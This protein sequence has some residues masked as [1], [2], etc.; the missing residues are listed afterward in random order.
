MHGSINFH[1]G[2]Y[3]QEKYRLWQGCPTILCTPKGRLFAGWYSGGTKEP[4]KSCFNLLFKSDDGGLHWSDPLLVV[5]SLKEDNI[6]CIDIQLWLDPRGRMWLCWT[7]RDMNHTIRTPE[8]LQTYAAICEDPDAEELTF[9]PPRLIAPGFLRCQPTVLSDGRILLCAYDWVGKHYHYSESAD[10]GETWVRK[11]GGLKTSYDLSYDE[12]MILELP[13]GTLRLLAR[14][15]GG[16]GVLME[17]ISHDGGKTWS[18]AAKSDIT[19]PGSRF[20]I[21]RLPSGRVLLVKNDSPDKRI[22]MTAYL[23]E[24]DGRTWPW[25]L[26]ID[27]RESS[28]PD[29]AVREDGTIYLIHDRGRT[30]FK[31][32][33]ISRFTEEDILK[34]EVTDLDS[35]LCH[36]ISKSPG[37][38]QDEAMA[39]KWE[40]EDTEF[41]ANFLKLLGLE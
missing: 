21:R 34:G 22:K 35:F 2:K 38:P 8:H 28:Y 39:A 40:K 13:G 19:A 30:T 41:K 16:E 17:S 24:D 12:D 23:S 4:S 20:F 33:Y 5:E 9:L 10:G 25:S 11:T 1:P 18:D 26:Q 29:C 14:T 31:E 27:P 36:M 37:K 32:I 7:Q 15:D 6:L 3:H